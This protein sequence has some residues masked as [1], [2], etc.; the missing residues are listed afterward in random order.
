MAS[1][2]VLGKS[3]LLL[4]LVIILALFGLLW[5]D[6]L[7]VIQPK[8]LFAP[9]YR[10]IG[11]EPQTS[12]S[13]ST[14]KNLELADLDND[15]FAKRLEALDLRTQELDKREE[16]VQ[17]AERNNEKI[18]QELKDQL[19]AQEEREKTFNNERKKYDDRW[20]NIEQI[21]QNLNGMQPANA[22]AIL[23]EMDDQDIIDVLRRA[24]ELA[25]EE[26]GSS[27]GSYW[28]SQMPANRAAEIQRKMA[29]RPS[30]LD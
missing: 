17:E 30:S 6:Y 20:R 2:K 12:T 11:L 7:G 14:T 27:M 26:G 21:V 25:Q 22:V 28:L 8:S 13:A 9:V 15:R 10:L 23:L 24:E 1:G 16:D 29:N 5:F 3:I 4:I 19:S 18:A